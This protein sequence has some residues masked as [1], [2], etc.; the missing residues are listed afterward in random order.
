MADPSDRRVA[1]RLGFCGS[2]GNVL[3]WSSPSFAP[4]DV[5]DKWVAG[6]DGDQTAHSTSTVDLLFSPCMHCH[7]R[8]KGAPV[9]SVRQALPGSSIPDEN[10][11]KRLCGVR[12]NTGKAI[13]EDSMVHSMTLADDG[14]D[15]LLLRL[16]NL[17]VWLIEGATLPDIGDDKS[18]WDVHTLVDDDGAIVGAATTFRFLVPFTRVRGGCRADHTAK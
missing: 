7:V 2:D 8:G 17:F 10:E 16:L 14:A 6:E 11:F 13:H 1:I 5:D 15:E 9:D 12:E 4:D 18:R 3:H